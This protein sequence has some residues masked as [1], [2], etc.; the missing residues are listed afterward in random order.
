MSPNSQVVFIEGARLPNG[1]A[2]YLWANADRNKQ[3]IRDCATIISTLKP[4]DKWREMHQSNWF[5]LA[6]LLNIPH[7]EESTKKFTQWRTN[8]LN[9]KI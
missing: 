7:E 4:K 5:P 3:S 6:S 1:L 9:C 2:K 8:K